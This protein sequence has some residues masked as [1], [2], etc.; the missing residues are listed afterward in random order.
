MNNPS[1]HGEVTQ[2][3]AKR[4]S[5]GVSAETPDWSR[6][7]KRAVWDPSRALIGAI[8]A[9]Q[10]QAGKRGPLAAA[11]R[12]LAVWRHRFWS[13]VTGAD[14]SIKCRIGGGLLMPHPNGIVIHEHA[15]IGPN[16]LIMQ[17]VTIGVSSGT[18][19]PEI[20]GHVDIS[21]GAAILGPVKVGDHAVIGAHALVVKDIAA[22]AVVLSPLGQI[23]TEMK[24]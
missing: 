22:G 15:V 11:R 4:L 3:S 14:I 10:R 6:E 8:R 5:D 19:V 16:C 17:Q 21:V 1:K 9:Y 2:V 12:R 20:G 13:V 7:K 18:G 23:K 24:A